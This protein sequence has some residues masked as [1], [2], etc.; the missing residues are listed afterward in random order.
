V[1]RVSRRLIF[2]PGVILAPALDK[3][4]SYSNSYYVKAPVKMVFLDPLVKLLFKLGLWKE[5]L[6]VN[7]FSCVLSVFPGSPVSI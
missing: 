6:P 3:S 5:F 1:S 4:Y 2:G 7:G